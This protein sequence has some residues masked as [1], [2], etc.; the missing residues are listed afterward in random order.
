MPHDPECV[1]CQIVAGDIP[2]SLVYS[3]ES[4]VAFLDVA[5]LAE[6]HLLIV[7]REHYS[8]LVE[9][10]LDLAGELGAAIPD[11]G[12]A[13]MEA[14][15]AEGFNVLINQG[16]VAGQVVPHV[17]IHLIPRREG[18]ELGYRWKAGKYPPGKEAD[19]VAAFREALSD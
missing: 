19:L 17:H 12:R 14:T 11:L 3:D 13:L 18:D 1:F 10:P 6:G 16:A 2:A 7:P 4:L 8:Q 15:G 5:P 9:L